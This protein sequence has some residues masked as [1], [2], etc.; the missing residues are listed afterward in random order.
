M[1]ADLGGVDLG[2]VLFPD[3]DETEGVGDHG[4]PGVTLAGL[5]G[6]LRTKVG[7]GGKDV[8]GL[9]VEGDGASAGLGFEQLLEGEAG[10]R[11]FLD[12]GERSF[13]LGA[14]GFHG[15]GVE[16][17]A[18]GALAGGE[19]FK[20]FAVLCV[21]DDH[22]FLVAAGGEE[23]VVDG[24]DGEAG[25]TATFAGD[26]VLAGEREGFG[27]DDGDGILVF[28]IDEEV[29]VVIENGLL[30]GAAY[31]EGLDDV[32]GGGVKDGDVGGDVGEDEDA[33]GDGVVKVAIGVALGGDGLDDL[34]G[35]GVEHG[36]GAAGGEAV[37]GGVVDRCAVGAAGG[38]VAD[39]GESVKVI[40]VDAAGG[41]GAREIEAAVGGICR[42]I[43]PAT[44][45]AEL[46]GGENLVVSGL[47][48]R[49]G[50]R[51]G[52]GEGGKE[53]G[54]GERGGACHDARSIRREGLRKA[55][56]R[57]S[58]WAGERRWGVTAAAS[59]VCTATSRGRVARQ[60]AEQYR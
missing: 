43:V 18:V 38:D 58:R 60:I 14:E 56:H 45:A 42:E 25:A 54:E 12:D 33:V 30:D 7:G 39:G 29:A 17:G 13:T 34:E 52:R 27:V 19:D 8:P 23:D 55:E 40:D 53:E 1:C 44:V 15:A 49:R 51:E 41:A 11:V 57:V 3:N 47:G 46:V 32:A 36:D 16:G 4:R 10:G 50:G 26:V 20:D 35:P 48:E 22:V 6:G 59:R 28:E 31:V 9:L 21:E 37:V 5:G 24:V 2:K